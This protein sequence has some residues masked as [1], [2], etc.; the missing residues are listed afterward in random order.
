MTASTSSLAPLAEDVVVLCLSCVAVVAFLHHVLHDLLTLVPALS[1]G[2]RKALA[3]LDHHGQ[4]LPRSFAGGIV[5]GWG[6]QEVKDQ[7]G[8]IGKRLPPRRRTA[9]AFSFA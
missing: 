4:N 3:V 2:C 1:S 8:A 7:D 6:F 9:A 5:L